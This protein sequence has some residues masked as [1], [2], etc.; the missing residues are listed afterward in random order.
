MNVLT[1]KTYVESSITPKV[2][3]VYASVLGAVFAV[4]CMAMNA[5]AAD[6]SSSGV[7]DTVTSSMTEQLTSLV[8]KAGVA[9]AAVV[10]IGLTIFGVKWLIGVLKSFFSKLTH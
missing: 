1:K 3:K 4:S 9:I 8:T 2:K 5:F 7:L 6:S 10:G